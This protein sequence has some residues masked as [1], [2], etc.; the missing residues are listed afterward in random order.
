MAKL[1]WERSQSTREA[2]KQHLT[3]KDEALA[4]QWDAFWEACEMQRYGASQGNLDALAQTLLT[5]GETTESS[6]HDGEKLKAVDPV[7]WLVLPWAGLSQPDVDFQ[8]ANQA[9]ES[10]NYEEVGSVRRHPC[11][12][13]AFRV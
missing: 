8:R 13:S 6:G 4:E 2:V 11:H 3:V 10:G 1:G 12:A 7:G 5:L 9:Y